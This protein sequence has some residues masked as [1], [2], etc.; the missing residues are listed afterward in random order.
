MPPHILSSIGFIAFAGLSCFHCWSVCQ[1][2]RYYTPTLAAI[3]AIL[4]GVAWLCALAL[5]LAAISRNKLRAALLT[6]F[7]YAMAIVFLGTRV[8]EGVPSEVGNTKWYDPDRRLTPGSKYVLHNHSHVIRP[9]SEAEYRLYGNLAGCYFSAG[10]MLFAAGLCLM[11]L[12][13]DGQLG[14]PA[15]RL[16][17]I[18]VFLPAAT[19][20]CPSCNGRITS[21]ASGRWPPWCPHCG[22]AVY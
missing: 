18:E 21:D 12:D 3:F 6:V 19:T 17:A 9:L 8:L 10:F 4:L 16:P 22:G 14:R 11:P 2:A 13:R 15:R 20:T 7:L 1:V 5:M